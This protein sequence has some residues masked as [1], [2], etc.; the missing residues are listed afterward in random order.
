MIVCDL[1]RF[2]HV[3]DT[4]AHEAGDNLLQAFAELVREVVGSAGVAADRWRRVR[5]LP[6]RSAYPSTTIDSE[7]PT[8]GHASVRLVVD[9]WWLR[10]IRSAVRK[11]RSSWGLDASARRPQMRQRKKPQLLKSRQHPRPWRRRRASGQPRHLP[12]QTPDC[13]RLVSSF[14][15]DHFDIGDG[16]YL[17]GPPDP[18]PRL[19]REDQHPPMIGCRC[20]R[21]SHAHALDPAARH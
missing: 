2:K 15:K 12:R 13:S 3:N 10:T 14:R 17:A 5:A 6:A 7:G 21:G 9:G 8:N 1:D 16:P 19:P 20:A 11:W 18:F 4:W